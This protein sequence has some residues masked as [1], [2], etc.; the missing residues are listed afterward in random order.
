MAVSQ[1]RARSSSRLDASIPDLAAILSPTTYS[2]AQY[3]DA[4]KRSNGDVQ[5]AAELLLLSSASSSSSLVIKSDRKRGPAKAGLSG[6]LKKDACDKD[7]TKR[8]RRESIQASTNA[9][10]QSTDV[11]DID[12][13]D[14]PDVDSEPCALPSKTK[15]QVSKPADSRPK[16]DAFSVLQKSSQTLQASWPSRNPPRPPVILPTAELVERHLP[17]CSIHDSPLSADFASSLYLTLFEESRS[18][19]KYEWFLAGRKVESTHTSCYY[20]LQDDEADLEK[21]HAASDDYWYAGQRSPPAPT[22]PAILREAARRIEPVV[23]AIMADRAKLGRRHALEFDGPWRANMAAVN[24]YPGAGSSVG[25]HGDQLTYLGPYPTIA[26]L[27]LGTP[28][29]F[30]LRPNADPTR[31]DRDFL[32]RELRTYEVPLGHNSLFIMHGGTQEGFKHTVPPAKSLDLFRPGWDKDGRRLNPQNMVGY[33]SRINIT[34]R[35]YRPDFHPT[36]GRSLVDGKPREGTPKCR[37]GI[38]R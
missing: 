17:S 1:D 33:G 14:V 37:C 25:W 28:R 9:S 12:A 4:L 22:F 2:N 36:P 8:R 26:S 35:F 38:P 30:R 19:S 6:W 11:I 13:I 23:N 5:H 34:F 15:S 32:G 31:K 7:S 29:A 3:I 20:R 10:N 16:V 18:W 27:S 24:H 21:G